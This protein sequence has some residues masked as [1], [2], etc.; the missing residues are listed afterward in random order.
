MVPQTDE[1]SLQLTGALVEGAT[2]EYPGAQT[3]RVR[4]KLVDEAI[5][6]VEKV[7]DPVDKVL[8]HTIQGPKA[9]KTIQ[10]HP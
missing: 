8:C 2:H 7:R 4:V 6:M 5:E 1:P 3:H 10:P 9:T